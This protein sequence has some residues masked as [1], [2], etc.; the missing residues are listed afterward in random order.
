M[1]SREGFQDML[2]LLSKIWFQ[3]KAQNQ[4]AWMGSK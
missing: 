1:W 3:G 4:G 2:M